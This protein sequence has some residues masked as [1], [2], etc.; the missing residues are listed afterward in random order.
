[1]AKK[2]NVVVNDEQAFGT[3]DVPAVDVQDSYEWTQNADGKWMQGKRIGT[4]YTVLCLNDA[5]RHQ[6]VDTEEDAPL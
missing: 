2:L 4:R 6:T 3:K 1:M 5:A